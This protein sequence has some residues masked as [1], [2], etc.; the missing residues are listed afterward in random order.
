MR[1]SLLSGIYAAYCWMLFFILAPVTW[2]TVVVMP[3]EPWRWI[4]MRKAGRLLATAS[5][6]PLTVHGLENLPQKTSCILVS[7]HTSYL[8][9]FVMA[10]ILPLEFSFV[11]KAELKG[12]FLI[13]IFLNRIQTEFVERFD[14]Q[15]GVE[16]A[17]HIAAGRTQRPQ[18]ALF[19]EGTFTRIPGLRPFHMGAFE[20]AVEADVP[21]VPIA[22]RGTRSM[23]RDVSLFPRRGSIT[24]TIGKPIEP[25]H[26]QDLS[27]PDS[28]TTAIKLRDAVR[29]HILKHCGEPD[30][31]GH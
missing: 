23:L 20:T 31:S 8:D 25:R 30:L 22:I 24:V 12:N 17:R 10:S 9:N 16:D 13:R 14:R 4:V 28:W 6:T 27:A 3:K 7:N 5:F 26:L 29:E 1:H 19:A 15:K 11:A 2:L 18:P 21:V